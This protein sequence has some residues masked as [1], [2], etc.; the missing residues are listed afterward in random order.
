VSV[1]ALIVAIA[2]NG[3]IGSVG[4]IPWRIPEDMRHFK[5]VTMGK[6][7]IMGRKTWDSLPN[8]PLSG[9]TNIVVTANK[10]FAAAGAAVA[11]TLDE[12]I[13]LAESEY[14]DEIA[15]IGGSEIYNAALPCAV[16]IYLTEVH[17]AYA[18]DA[19]FQFDRTAWRETAREDRKSPHGLRYSFVTLVRREEPVRIMGKFW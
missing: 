15:V 10:A 19:T 16:R 17:R 12:A 6:P 1:I 2:D 3:V 9:R 7:C 5:A 13:V 18:G 8:K 11:H 4:Q 14:P